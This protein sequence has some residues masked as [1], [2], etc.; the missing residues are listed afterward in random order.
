[1]P[2]KLPAP[3][4][5]AES[6]SADFKRYFHYTLGRDDFEHSERHQFLAFAYA[7]R[8]RMVAL[9][10]NTRHAYEDAD[11]RRTCYLSMEYLIGR[12]LGNL[13][14]STVFVLGSEH[15]SGLDTVLDE[16]GEPQGLN[17]ARMGIDLTVEILQ[18][19]PFGL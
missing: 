18:G 13:P 1:M 4:T 7:L 3:G 15:G 5:D 11:V 19:N 6:L 12:S 9:G 16:V 17:V 10:N 2:I 8:D 14:L